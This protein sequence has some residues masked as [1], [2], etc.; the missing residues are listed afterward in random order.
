MATD[1]A[2]DIVTDT[3][4]APGP[5]L[6]QD[7]LNLLRRKNLFSFSLLVLLTLAAGLS[8]H[9]GSLALPWRELSCLHQ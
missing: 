5:S 9:T 8:L 1:T 4:T 6:A 3:M 7:Y 2:T